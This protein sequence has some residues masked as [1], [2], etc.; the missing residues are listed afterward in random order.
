MNR[1]ILI[2]LVALG[3]AGLPSCRPERDPG[4]IRLGHF[5]NLTH[6]QGLVAHQLTRRGECWFE[7]RLGVKVEWFIY[8]A[9]PS[10]TEAIFAGSLDAT[11]IG[12]G[13]VLN[14]YSK[15]AG[16][17]MRVLAGGAKGGNALLVRAGSGIN[18]PE[19][20]RGKKIASPQLGN[21]QDIQLRA[22]LAEHGLHVSYTGGDAFVVPTENSSQLALLKKEALD[23]VW[24]AEPWV[25]LLE[26]E[27]GA[28][29]FHQD[30]ETTVTLLAASAEL[31]KNSPD[32]ARK[33]VAA[34]RELTAWIIA[35][36]AEVRE[37]IKAELAAEMKAAPKDELIDRAYARVIVT[38]AVSRESL[39]QMVAS[40][41]KAGFLKGIPDLGNL[42]PS[43]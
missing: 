18:K 1:R 40:A 34:H 3:L 37:L 7:K 35:H 24:S 27:A 8:N 33:L 30:T 36:P 14:A 39:E 38:D 9:G 12:P 2:L 15:S 32:L 19:D 5:P 26:M 23:A 16:G 13:P 22:W 29:V 6:V 41:K 43:L 42:M 11:Y 20:F 17:E 10:A 31:V 21:T 28:K 25:T 4:V